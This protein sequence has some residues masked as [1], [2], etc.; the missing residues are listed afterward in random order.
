MTQVI[1]KLYVYTN[2]ESLFTRLRAL[3]RHT[4][5]ELD[6]QV[7]EE[8]ELGRAG[9]PVGVSGEAG[10]VLMSIDVFCCEQGLFTGVVSEETEVV[11]FTARVTGCC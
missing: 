6:S 3:R 10:G 7:L 9:A 2:F 1:Q 5:R 8:P 4:E 11:V